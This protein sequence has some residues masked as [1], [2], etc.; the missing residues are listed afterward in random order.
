MRGLLKIF[1]TATKYFEEFLSNVEEYGMLGYTIDEIVEIIEPSCDK[2]QLA[3]VVKDLEEYDN[4]LARMYRNG[5]ARQK[6][7]RDQMLISQDKD[8]SEA[9]LNV[10]EIKREELLAQ[11]INE[12]YGL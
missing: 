9:A 1:E 11:K 3:Q 7:D 4:I 5:K 8:S 12:Y 2:E 6:L 10:I